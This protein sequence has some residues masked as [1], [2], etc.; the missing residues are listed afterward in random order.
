MLSASFSKKSYND[1]KVSADKVEIEY[2]HLEPAFSNGKTGAELVEY[3]SV[4]I[5]KVNLYDSNKKVS[6]FTYSLDP[7]GVINTPQGILDALIS[8]GRI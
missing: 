1:L 3:P 2:F 5:V 4:Y 7:T 8:K 6:S